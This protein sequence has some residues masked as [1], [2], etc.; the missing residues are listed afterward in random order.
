MGFSRPATRR[1]PAGDALAQVLVHAREPLTFDELMQA[2][3]Q[4]SAGH[5]AA[6]LG[7]AIE[8][9]LVREERSTPGHRSRYALKARGRRLILAGRR[10]D[11]RVA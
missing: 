7:H 1:I 6:W 2:A 5:V 8:E 3:D 11:E 4:H 9:G 10:S